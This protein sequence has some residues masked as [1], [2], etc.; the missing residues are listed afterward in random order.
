MNCKK[1]KDWLLVEYPDREL[2]SVENAV[3]REHLAGCA[4][5]RE[6]YG[7]LQRSAVAPFKA[8][9]EIRPPEI[10]WRRIQEKIKSERLHSRGWFAELVGSFA[11]RLEN[12][13]GS[14]RD[15]RLPVPVRAAFATALVLGVV[16][17]A[18]W[19]SGAIDPAYA[20][21]AEQM[22][23]MK[24]LSSGNTEILNGDLR[25]YDVALEQISR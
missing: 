13:T 6:F 23:F 3:V 10:V 7:G 9:E 25:E 5:C 14:L 19:P 22:S 20:Y 21:V 2:G 24:E 16:V 8:A 18:R 1:M 17:F 12:L 15:F 4:D 11:L